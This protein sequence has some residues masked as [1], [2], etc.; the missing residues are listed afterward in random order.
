MNSQKTQNLK[1]PLKAL[2]LRVYFLIAV[3]LISAPNTG[4]CEEGYLSNSGGRIQ[5][6]SLYSEKKNPFLAPPELGTLKLI[7]NIISGRDINKQ[8]N[9]NRNEEFFKK[10]AFSSPSPPRA[11]P[12][13]PRIAILLPLTGQHK[14]LGQAMLNAA[15]LALFHF[16]DIRFELLPQDTGGT[17]RGALDAVAEAIGND[18]SLIL[19][20]LFAGS[21]AAVAPAARA[22]GVK[23]IAFS[24]DEKVAGDGVFTMGFLPRE[25]VRRVV[26]Y[27]IIQGR[28]RF[29][30]LAPDNDY[31]YTIVNALKEVVEEN[32]V[33][34]I[35]QA[36]Y[37]P[38]VSDLGP[39][40]KSLANYDERRRTLLDERRLLEAR[41]DDAAKLALKK[42]EN[43]E[44]KGD[45]SFEALLIADGGETLQAIAALLP[46]YDIDPKK[47]K[48]LGTGH[49]DLP[50]IGSEP[51]LVGGWFAAPSSDGRR[52]FEKQYNS[53]FGVMAPRLAT[54]AYDAT[55]LAAVFSQTN[56]KMVNQTSRSA[57]KLSTF[58][59]PQGFKG[60]DGVFRFTV[61]GFVE[62]GLSVFQVGERKNKTIS[63]APQLFATDFN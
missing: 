5:A 63:Q 26:N 7:N 32:G 10:D 55:A 58:L 50:G 37:D 17:E 11:D 49:W 31:G 28:R 24:N 35:E 18:A 39:V 21:V 33:D 56:Q 15:Q 38:Y 8:M 40:I 46:Y 2:M 14:K 1:K 13:V 44:T 62:R 54:L 22:A 47:I 9:V 25:Q 19:G 3:L 12:E 43:L 52:E 61:T 42:L 4:I 57:Y 60:L 27:A 41:D 51:A 48:M 45:V 34:L 20:P 36:F 16:A 6:P 59:A 23:V 53:I 29:A 30:V